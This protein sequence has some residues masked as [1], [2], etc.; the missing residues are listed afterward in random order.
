[1]PAHSISAAGAAGVRAS[2]RGLV[3][4][5]RHLRGEL[6]AERRRVED[7]ARRGTPGADA[8][9]ACGV[10]IT[11]ATVRASDPLRARGAHQPLHA[12]DLRFE[13]LTA[14]ARQPIVAAPLVDG[15]GRAVALLDPARL[16]QPL[17]RAVDRPGPEPHRAVGVTQHVLEDAVAVALA[18]GEREQDVEDGGA[19]ARAYDPREMYP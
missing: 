1:M 18:A 10:T 7:T 11:R 14:G 5:A 3:E 4:V 8:C 9:A 19:S 13:R 6:A 12:L 15:G 16:H 2:S 17:Q